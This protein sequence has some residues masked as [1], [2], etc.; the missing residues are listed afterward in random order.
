MDHRGV[1]SL[2][3]Q[4]TPGRRQDAAVLVLLGFW[5]RAALVA[6]LCHFKGIL[7]ES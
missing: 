3:L 1:G 4:N 6:M 5:S 7:R 2:A